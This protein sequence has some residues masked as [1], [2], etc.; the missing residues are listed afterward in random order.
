MALKDYIGNSILIIAEAGVNHNGRI[1]LAYGLVDAA[2]KAGADAVKFQTFITE[3]SISKYSGLAKYQKDRLGGHIGQFEMAKALELSFEEFERLKTYSDEKGILFL[4]TP[5]EEESL[6]FLCSL[7]IPLIKIGSGEVS[8]IPFLRY[9]AKKKR[10]VILSTGMCDDEEVK[11]AVDAICGEGCTDVALLHCT[12]E[13]PAPKN[14][15]N[16][17]AMLTLR[18]KFGLPVGYSDH[19]LGY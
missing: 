14:E 10:P 1:D 16:L 8:N 9:A 19:T 7:G 13:Y 18:E 6:D 5:D 2:K 17:R 4:S 11:D 15:V 12:T 3:K